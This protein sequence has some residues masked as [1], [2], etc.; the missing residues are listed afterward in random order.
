MPNHE[1]NSAESPVPSRLGIVAGTGAFPVLIARAARS[2]GIEVVGFCLSKNDNDGLRPHVD[3]LHL[4][5]LHNVSAM[6][7]LA[8]REGIRHLILAGRVPHELLLNPM[9]LL[10]GRVRRIMSALA[11]R[12]ADTVLGAFTRELESEGFTILDS[13]QFVES[14]MPEPGWL[15][16]IAPSE[17]IRRDIEF[18][19]RTAKAVAGLDIGQTVAVK[20]GIVVAVEALEGTDRLILRAGEL[21]G[22]GVVIVKVA[23]PQ[24]SLKFDVPIVGLQTIRNLV[25]AKVAAMAVTARRSLL[26]DRPEALELARRHGIVIYSHD[27]SQE[28]IAN[29][30][31]AG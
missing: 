6:V 12:K 21:A 13:T 5:K 28:L 19:Y 16:G 2:K 30:E 24:Q 7:E 26:F 23:K 3:R 29:A 14:A 4:I 9:L 20:Q 25:E 15:T 17:E 31:S 1:S 10:D 11:N 18:G 27:E 22:E 8:H